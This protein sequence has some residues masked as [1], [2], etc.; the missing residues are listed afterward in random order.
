MNESII[1]TDNII[2]IVV[3]NVIMMKVIIVVTFSSFLAVPSPATTLREIFILFVTPLQMS[4]R[5]TDW[6]DD[7][8]DGRDGDR[9]GM[10]DDED[11]VADTWHRGRA[12]Q[13]GLAVSD[14][15]LTR[16]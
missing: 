9:D 11:D 13:G 6:E 15:A 14:L 3:L 1:T 7:E 10:D 12:Q 8:D 4:S 2:I 5:L 16:R